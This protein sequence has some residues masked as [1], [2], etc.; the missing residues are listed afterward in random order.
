MELLLRFANM[1]EEDC[2]PEWLLGLYKEFGIMH[3]MAGD[4][5][6]Y[7]HFIITSGMPGYRFFMVDDDPTPLEM[8]VFGL[9]RVSSLDV[10]FQLLLWPQLSKCRDAIRQQ[11]DNYASGIIDID[12]LN[13]LMGDTTFRFSSSLDTWK[14][15]LES[16]GYSTGTI[17]DYICKLEIIDMFLCARGDE[18]SR[19]RKCANCGKYFYATHK[20][21]RLFCSKQC[22]SAYHYRPTKE[23]M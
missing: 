14:P 20:N 2:T 15:K 19:V 13:S 7:E 9:R 6:G 18:F 23:A 8:E 11:L 16:K 10:R 5:R 1:R 17:E 4:T 12:Y 3:S 21:N 22:K